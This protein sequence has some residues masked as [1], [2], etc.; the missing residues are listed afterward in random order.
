[1]FGN[2]ARSFV[3][4]E[5]TP[6]TWLH[7]KKEARPLD[8]LIVFHEKWYILSHRKPISLPNSLSALSLSRENSL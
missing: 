7:P 4:T 1:M 2:F 6:G 5:G 8:H 3:L